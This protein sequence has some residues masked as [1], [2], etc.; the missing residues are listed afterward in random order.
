MTWRLHIVLGGEWAG[1]TAQRSQS[2]F[3]PTFIWRLSVDLEESHSSNPE[4]VE[5]STEEKDPGV[6][7]VPEPRRRSVSGS[8]GPVSSSSG[9]HCNLCQITVNSQSQLAQV[10]SRGPWLTI[11]P[12]DHCLHCS[13]PPLTNTGGWVWHYRPT[14][15][16][17]AARTASL[18]GQTATTGRFQCWACSYSVYTSTTTFLPSGWVSGPRQTIIMSAPH[19]LTTEQ[20][21]RLPDWIGSFRNCKHFGAIVTFNLASVFDHFSLLVPPWSQQLC[22]AASGVF[23]YQLLWTSLIIGPGYLLTSP[24]TIPPRY[25][26]VAGSCLVSANYIKHCY[27]PAILGRTGP[28]SHHITSAC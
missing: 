3:T 1:L 27:Q 16:L 25:L 19:H 22:C 10:S 5:D 17:P 9:Y 12:T 28:Y 7:S 15:S 4:L 18:R 13:T 23:Q 14:G 24:A 21:A 11:T 8:Y 20:C 2:S 26:L 6:S